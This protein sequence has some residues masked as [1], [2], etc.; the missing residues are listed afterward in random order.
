MGWTVAETF[1]FRR[2]REVL[3][4]CRVYGSSARPTQPV[5]PVLSLEVEQPRRELTHSVFYSTEFKNAR[6]RACVSKCA[7]YGVRAVGF[8]PRPAMRNY[9]AHRRFSEI[10]SF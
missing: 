5:V 7:Y 1:D 10:H 4:F 8:N 9:A 2:S 3:L 6:G